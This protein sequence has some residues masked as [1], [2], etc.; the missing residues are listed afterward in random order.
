MGVKKKDEFEGT[1]LPNH[2]NHSLIAQRVAEENRTDEFL[3]LLG[4][5][6]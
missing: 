5:R 2:S 3:Q 6:T 1:P 4:Q